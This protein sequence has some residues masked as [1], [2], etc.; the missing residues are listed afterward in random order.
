MPP[1][2][3]SP[4]TSPFGN[5]LGANCR[6][7]C[8]AAP[9][10]KKSLPLSNLFSECCCGKSVRFFVKESVPVSAE[11]SDAACIKT[12]TRNIVILLFCS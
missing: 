3:S 1:F 7:C 10:P 12:G 5:L 2:R 4:S 11:R 8:V 6:V 9:L